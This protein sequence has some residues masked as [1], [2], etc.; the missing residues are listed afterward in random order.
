MITGDVDDAGTSVQ[1][2]QNRIRNDIEL[3]VE[4]S[5]YPTPAN[6]SAGRLRPNSCKLARQLAKSYATR[7]PSPCCVNLRQGDQS[8]E[9]ISDSI[10]C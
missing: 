2:P 7:P 10:R 1:Q 4:T 6:S 8:N 9:E 3:A 5:S